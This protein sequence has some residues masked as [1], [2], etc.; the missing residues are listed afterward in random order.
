MLQ[1]F[2]PRMANRLIVLIISLSYL[3][4][5]SVKTDDSKL[6]VTTLD[7]YIESYKFHNFEDELKVIMISTKLE[8]GAMK[9]IINDAPRK[10]FLGDLNKF[11]QNKKPSIFMGSYNNIL[12]EIQSDS[13]QKY[14][15]LFGNLDENIIKEA[16]QAGIIQ[17]KDGKTYD[18]DMSLLNWTPK[19]TIIYNVTEN[20]KEIVVGE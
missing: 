7:N 13:L 20:T 10:V 11:S 1:N 5:S 17:A 15:H 6:M 12:C 14:K 2:T 4:C 9:Y 8:N 19:L 18:L 3:S 16:K